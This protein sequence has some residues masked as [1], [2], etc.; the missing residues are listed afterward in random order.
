VIERLA[1]RGVLFSAGSDAH[2]AAH[3]GQVD[4]AYAEAARLGL[5]MLC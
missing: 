5:K 1:A 3:I 4:F 2:T